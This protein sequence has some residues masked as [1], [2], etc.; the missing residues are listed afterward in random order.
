M[1]FYLRFP[2]ELQI[3]F[4]EKNTDKITLVDLVDLVNRVDSVVTLLTLSTILTLSACAFLSHIY[5]HI[6]WWGQWPVGSKDEGKI[7]NG[8]S[9]SA[10]V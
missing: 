9:P 10:K 5:D 6:S 4:P 8:N 7:I 3:V 1:S 2:V